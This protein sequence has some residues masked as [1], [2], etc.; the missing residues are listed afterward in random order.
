[1]IFLEL[2]AQGVRGVTPAGGRVALR[3]GYN[4]LAAD[5]A[6]LQ[7]LV[8]ALLWPDAVGV[9][10]VPRSVAGP[11]A[12]SARV[13]TTLLGSDN[14]TY[15]L[16]RDLPGSCQLHRFDPERRSFA[17][18]SQELP[19][20]GRYLASPG[21][22]PSQSR[23]KALLTVCAADL[24]SRQP[25]AGPRAPTASMPPARR[26]LGAEERSRKIS[27][28]Q[29]ELGKANHAEKR[30]YQLDGLQSKLF[31]LEETLRSGVKVREG[32][33]TSEAALHELAP[34]AAVA[35]LGDLEARVAA[36]EKAKEKLED[37]VSRLESERAALG[38]EPPPAPTPFWR[39][40]RFLTAAGAGLA[41]A[42]LAAV[43]AVVGES[44]FRYLALLDMPAFAYAGYVA[45][46][47]VD[48]LEELERS[49]R[50]RKRVQE[51][52]QKIQEQYERET[53]QV[54]GAMAT[55]GLSSFSDLKDA[56]GRLEDARAVVAEWRRRLAE[57]EAK[58]E[59]RDAAAE[60]ERVEAEIKEVETHL[61]SEVGG[62]V[63]D[64]RTIEMEIA[65]VEA[66]VSAPPSPAPPAAAATS[67]PPAGD[68]LRA[69]LD[70]AAAE[71]HVTPAAALRIASQRVA[72][73]LPTLSAQRLGSLFVDDRG[74]VLV[75]GGGRTVPASSLPPADRDLCF[76][77]LRMGLLE[78]A[79]SAGKAVA[80]IDDAFSGLPEGIRRAAAR[81]LK[82]LARGGQILHATSDAV[83]REAADHAA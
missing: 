43:A 48:A 39:D 14:V 17:L 80:L 22:A 59:T 33:E 18:V 24:P 60:K 9:E 52:E 4:V 82:Q 44:S 20:I 7:R 70:G 54:R 38:E 78:H 46:R 81:L 72:Q 45:W 27:Q 15:R 10:A 1:V 74:N 6:A 29:A 67:T 71:L 50:R 42:L 47:W 66:E 49:G 57:W 75:Q 51:W 32:L 58:P 3:P 41:F 31:K 26:P 53:A 25:A 64:P 76:L 63:R 62:Y 8:E 61:A 13:G 36:F 21:G 34:V 83:F 65:L 40:P 2:A 5:G 68:S 11:G 37:G 30:Q 12:A 16:V 56:L 23:F 35:E 79:L 28:L 73:V 55:L 77:A 69:L 19:A